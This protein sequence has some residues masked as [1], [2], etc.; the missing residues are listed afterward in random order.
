MSNVSNPWLC[1]L[2][3]LYLYARHAVD[4]GHSELLAAGDVIAAIERGTLLTVVEQRVPLDWD[5]DA[6]R[7]A[8]QDGPVMAALQQVLAG[9]DWSGQPRD[10]DG[11]SLLA[12]LLQS[13]MDHGLW[14]V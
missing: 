4:E 10:D 1:S 13:C 12:T 6:L 14:V 9:G 2:A 5:F 11:L 7:H 3:Q 8:A